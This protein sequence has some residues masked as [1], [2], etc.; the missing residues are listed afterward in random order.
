MTEQDRLNDR[1]FQ[2]VQNLAE[3]SDRLRINQQAVPGGGTIFD[4]GV[5]VPGGIQAGLELSRICLADLA[6]VSVVPGKIAGDDWPCVQIVS[7]FPVEACLLSQYAGWQISVGEFFGMGSGPMRAAA[8]REELFQRMDYRE[9]PTNVVGVLEAASIPGSEVLAEIAEKTGVAPESVTLLIAPTSSQAGNLQVVSRSV[10]TALHKLF[11]LGFDARR[12]Q[13]AWGVAPLPPVAAN[14][15]EGIGRTNDA[16]LYGATVTVLVNGD[17]DSLLQI[18]P[19][20]PS[21]SSN[22]Y[23]KRFMEIFELANRDFYAIDPH[24]FSPAA[25]IFQNVDTG[26]IHRFGQVDEDILKRS[27]GLQRT[28]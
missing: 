19:Q 18:G 28:H 16:I 1:A 21:N 17:D 5:A 3:K 13:S 10:E 14:D 2:L 26:Q 27:F 22:A 20:V 7:D 11:E 4:F 24:L 12:V 15:L 6:A 8:A 9:S 23:G 25:I